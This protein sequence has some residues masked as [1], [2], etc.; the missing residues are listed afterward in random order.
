MRWTMAIM[1]WGLLAGSAS[2]GERLEPIKACPLTPLPKPAPVSRAKCEESYCVDLGGGRSICKCL[3]ELN[4][5]GGR[6]ILAEGEKTLQEWPAQAFL[7]E[8]SDFEVLSG[9]LRGDEHNLLVVANRAMTS[10]GIGIH[11]WSLHVLDPAKPDQPPISWSASDYG[12][13]SFALPR[14]RKEKGCDILV[15]D[16]LEGREPNGKDGLYF[17][18]RWF[19]LGASDL[20]RH[21]TRK[22]RLRRYLFSFER[23]RGRDLVEDEKD[24][25]RAFKGSPGK[26]LRPEKARPPEYGIKLK[27]KGFAP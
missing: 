6:F 27:E 7:N 26:W 3:S 9:D 23:E 1:V 20:E 2:A 16:W 10:Q 4:Q 21:P 13:G 22:S 8:T 15:T 19:R 14:S 18:G 24:V 12:H 11:Y 25:L 5:E 17:V